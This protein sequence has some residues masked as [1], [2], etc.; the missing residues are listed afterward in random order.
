MSCRE[1][2]ARAPGPAS[3]SERDDAPG[4][5]DRYLLVQAGEDLCV[6]PLARIRRIV[7]DLDVTPLP[8]TSAQLKGLAEFGGEPLPVLDLGQIVGAAPGATPPY[9]VTVIAWAGPWRSRELVGLAVDLVLE[10]VP[11]AAESTVA[12]GEG[13][14]RGEATVRDQAVRVISL[15]A[16]GSPA[17]ASGPGGKGPGRAS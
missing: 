13:V 8:G 17:G 16:L 14:V 15:A 5:G 1:R 3:G 12:G 6:L 10:V 2:T 7:R 4:T 9:S 11:V